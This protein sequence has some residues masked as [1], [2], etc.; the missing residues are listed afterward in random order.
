M[1]TLKGKPIISMSQTAD[2]NR[3]NV[4][5]NKQ[6][7]VELSSASQFFDIK[8]IHDKGGFSLGKGI[9]SYLSYCLSSLWFIFS[10]FHSRVISEFFIQIATLNP[11]ALPKRSR[12]AS[13]GVL[14]LFIILLVNLPIAAAGQQDGEDEEDAEDEEAAEDEEDAEDEEA[15]EDEEDAAEETPPVEA[16]TPPVEETPQVDPFRIPAD[17]QPNAIDDPNLQAEELV[18]GLIRPTAMAFLG[19]SSDDILVIEKDNG[20]VRRIIDGELQPEPLLDVA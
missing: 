6:Q 7:S 15:A 10:L 20:T 4:N 8:T 3:A 9:T 12:M 16:T 14:F 1:L 5:N 11:I 18:A 13:F 19:D 2:S 17:D